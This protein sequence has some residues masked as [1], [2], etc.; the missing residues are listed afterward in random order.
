MKI[1][2]GKLQGL[3]TRVPGPARDAYAMNIFRKHGA[4]FCSENRGGSLYWFVQLN[5]LRGPCAEDDDPAE[6]IIK[7][8]EILIAAQDGYDTDTKNT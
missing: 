8:Y 7:A 6:A 3:T 1:Q 2:D 4:Q 5:S